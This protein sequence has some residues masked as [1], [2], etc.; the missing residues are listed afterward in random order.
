VL[1]AVTLKGISLKGKLQFMPFSSSRLMLF[2]FV[3]RPELDVK[4]NI[5]GRFIGQQSIPQFAFLRA[6]LVSAIEKDFVEPNRGMVPLDY[7]PVMVLHP[8]H[9]TL[10]VIFCWLWKVRNGETSVQGDPLATTLRVKVVAVRGL[11]I[12]DQV[13]AG[14]KDAHEGEEED[15]TPAMDKQDGVAIEISN[16]LAVV[17]LLQCSC[18][19]LHASVSSKSNHWI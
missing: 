14:T 13:L 17:R 4:L 8:L 15:E 16:P 12:A 3:Q 1:P 10:S 11:T 2:S 9:T 5:R 7:A 18:E 19:L 6:A